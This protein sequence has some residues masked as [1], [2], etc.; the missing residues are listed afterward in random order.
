MNKL[1]RVEDSG[2]SEEADA[3]VHLRDYGDED[4]GGSNCPLRI[5]LSYQCLCLRCCCRAI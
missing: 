1:D 5:A 3:T 4:R 2:T